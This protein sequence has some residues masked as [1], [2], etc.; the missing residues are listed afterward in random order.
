MT[1]SVAVA[2]PAKPASAS[3]STPTPPVGLAQ[4]ALVTPFVL[5]AEC[6]SVNVTASHA[7]IICR[8]IPDSVI[9]K[10]LVAGPSIVISLIALGLSAYAVFYNKRKDARAREQSIQDEFWLRKI[11]SPASIEPFVKLSS[12]VIAELPDGTDATLSEAAVETWY[13]QY[14]TTLLRLK[15]GFKTLEL[16]SGGLLAQ[17]EAELES[18][19]DE[20]ATYVGAIRMYLN[21]G[22][23]LPV[24]AATVARLTDVRQTLLGLILKHQ[25]GLGKNSPN[26]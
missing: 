19:E 2:L 11:V 9:D 5:P 26:A 17:V 20:I 15:P 16:L 14:H 8:P 23:V 1:Q 25:V 24:R 7:V 10:L 13:G 3:S 4:V 6:G 12:D 21:D 22:G 18:F